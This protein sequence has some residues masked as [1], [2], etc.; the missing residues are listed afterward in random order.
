MTIPATTPAEE[1][2]VTLIAEAA[3]GPQREGLFALWLVVRAAEALLPPAPVSAKN[4]RRRLQAL[5][6]R[7]ASRRRHCAVR[8]RRPA[9]ISRP[10]RLTRPRWCSA[11]S[12]HP[13]AKSW[14]A[15]QPK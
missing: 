3:R 14:A 7:L 11:S 13:R 8:C 9:N 15:R 4:H 10:P 2:L 12:Q 1:R 6:S 5:E